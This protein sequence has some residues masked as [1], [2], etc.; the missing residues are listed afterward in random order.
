[1][2]KDFETILNGLVPAAA[3]D[4]IKFVLNDDGDI[5]LIKPEAYF[6][7]A[8]G[9]VDKMGIV[10]TI[11]LSNAKITFKNGGSL[12]LDEDDTENYYI[13]YNGLPGTIEDI[14]ANDIVWN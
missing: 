7:G 6:T 14:K 3:V 5:Q 10:D 8:V 12:D 2:N 1:M 4:Y 13:L 9:D 11:S